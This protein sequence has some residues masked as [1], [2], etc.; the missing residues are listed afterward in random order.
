MTPASLKRALDAFVENT[1]AEWRQLEYQSWLNGVYM[2]EVITT[3]FGKRHHKYPDNPMKPK[4]VIDDTKEY[5]EEEIEHYRD[6]FVKR[7]QRMEDRFN[8]A[9]EREK[10]FDMIMGQEDKQGS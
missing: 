9:K 7:L 2:I 8:K 5:T 1:E 10:I 3:C 4:V 6:Q